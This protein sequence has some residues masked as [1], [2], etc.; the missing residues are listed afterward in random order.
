MLQKAKA[1]EYKFGH[2]PPSAAP[3]KIQPERKSSQ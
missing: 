1:E 2:G 3:D